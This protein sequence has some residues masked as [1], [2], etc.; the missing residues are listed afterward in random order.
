[1][2]MDLFKPLVTRSALHPNF[3][4]TLRAPSTSVRKVL[5]EWA[6]GFP[7]RDGKFV[8][9]FQT[10]Y[11]SAFWELYLFAVFKEIGIKIDF[12]FDAPDFVAA[13]EP[14]A[15]EA[16]IASHAQDDIPEWEKRFEDVVDMGV[17]ESQARS[18]IR[19][20]NAFCAK[21]AAYLQ[22]YSKLPHMSGRSYVI[23]IS[24]YGTPDSNLLGDVP[25]Q[26][27]L[28]DNLDL[29]HFRKANGATV[30]LGLFRNDKFAHVSAVLYSSV[31]TFG[32]ARALSDDQ[33]EF[34]FQAFRIRN[35]CEPIHIVARKQDYQESLTD[36]LRLFMN[37]YA[38][39]PVNVD[40]FSDW[41][42]Q[43]FE[44]EKNG[45]FLVSCHPDGDLCMRQ[46]QQ[47]VE[48]GK[49]VTRNM[50]ELPTYIRRAKT[51]RIA[52]GMTQRAVAKL[53]TELCDRGFEFDKAWVQ[54]IEASKPVPFIEAENYVSALLALPQKSCVP[55]AVFSLRKRPR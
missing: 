41:G 54:C 33:N 45:D 30:P 29:G 55:D 38:R 22:R 52:A 37:P 35:H 17:F 7:D 44:A 46:L 10:T 31:A 53:A 50:L 4:G 27:V 40:L 6:K 2:V 14:I 15:F 18:A 21:S 39:T 24:N 19:A 28:Y 48:P 8:K 51:A 42:I 34:V 32:K 25:M 36:G 13:D 47:L 1:M 43:T 26:H 12:S 23:A 3:I 11:N 16:T 20:S 49:I 9:E 5:M